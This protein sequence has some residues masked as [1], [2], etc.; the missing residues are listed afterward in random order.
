MLSPNNL[1]DR[2]RAAVEGDDVAEVGD[3]VQSYGR[4]IDSLEDEAEAKE[5]ALRDLAAAQSQYQAM[6]TRREHPQLPSAR[7]AFAQAPSA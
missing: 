4:V 7:V 5:L 3:Q 6:E 2:L 1:S